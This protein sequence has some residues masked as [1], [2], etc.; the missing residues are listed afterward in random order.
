MIWWV[1]NNYIIIVRNQ[2]LKSNE[3]VFREIVKYVEYAYVEKVDWDSS[4]Q[5]AIDGFLSKLDPHSVYF[6]ADFPIPDYLK[7]I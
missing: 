1:N 2:T 5:G 6:P 3:S 7:Q 4:I